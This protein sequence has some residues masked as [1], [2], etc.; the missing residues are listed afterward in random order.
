MYWCTQSNVAFVSG[1]VLTFEVHLFHSQAN[2]KLILYARFGY[3]HTL[4]CCVTCLSFSFYLCGLRHSCTACTL[5]L[6]SCLPRFLWTMLFQL[7]HS[8]RPSRAINWRCG[9]L[10]ILRQYVWYMVDR[11]LVNLFYRPLCGGR[12]RSHFVS[13]SL[14]KT[15]MNHLETS[16]AD[17]AQSK[18]VWNENL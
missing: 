11:Y 6:I 15:Q 13:Q 4:V 14:A 9:I 2:S 1:V 3:F 18:D 10:I 12:S 8:L 7:R 17:S 5:S 16:D